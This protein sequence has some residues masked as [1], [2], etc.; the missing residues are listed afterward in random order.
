MK[1]RNLPVIAL[2]IFLFSLAFSGVANASSEETQTV[3]D[4]NYGG[5]HVTIIA[6]V[7]A[8]PGENITVNVK[9]S[10]SG[11]Q[12]IY[13]NYINLTFYGVVNS[14]TRTT[15]DEIAHL[16]DVSISSHDANYTLSIPNNIAP[17]LT[18]GEISCDWI[19]LSASTKNSKINLLTI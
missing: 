3:Y 15:L 2:C 9:T 1:L 12:Q 5:L 7:E 8:C 14:T 18:C 13:V 6:P 10:A 16:T 19:A 4:I 17:G 11:T